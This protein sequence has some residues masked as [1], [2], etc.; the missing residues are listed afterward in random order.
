MKGT[1][2]GRGDEGDKGRRNWE[3]AVIKGARGEGRGRR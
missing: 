3:E 1:R 2:E